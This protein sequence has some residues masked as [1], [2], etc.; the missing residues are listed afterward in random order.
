[1]V[2]VLL[3]R[4]SGRSYLEFN[5]PS[6]SG[7]WECT[8]CDQPLRDPSPHWYR[9]G[10]ERGSRRRPSPRQGLVAATSMLDP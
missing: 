5:S 9:R 6:G 7:S 3:K 2:E 4:K 8:W 1:M 10:P